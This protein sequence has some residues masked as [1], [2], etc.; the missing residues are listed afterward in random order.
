MPGRSVVC[1]ATSC[2]CSRGLPPHLFAPENRER[3]NII[4]SADRDAR[5][6]YSVG[7]QLYS[8][9][10][11]QNHPEVSNLGI[12]CGVPA[13]YDRMVEA[14]Y[15]YGMVWYGRGL[16]RRTSGRERLGPHR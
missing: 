9:N 3:G 5:P 4:M 6:E 15:Q 12:G 10:F 1:T 11:I 2:S 16:R 7:A 14:W 8:L 13:T